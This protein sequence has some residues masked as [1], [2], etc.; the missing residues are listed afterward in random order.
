MTP[1][2]SSAQLDLVGDQQGVDGRLYQVF[3]LLFISA[4][5]QPGQVVRHV[6]ALLLAETFG[7]GQAVAQRLDELAFISDRLV[8]RVKAAAV[9]AC[10]DRQRG[11]KRVDTAGVV[12]DQAGDL[13]PVDA[14]GA[15]DGLHKRVTFERTIKIHGREAGDVE[16][17]HPHGADKGDTQRVCGRFKV[18]G[19]LALLENLLVPGDIYALARQLKKLFAALH[20]AL[21]GRDDYRHLG[22]VHDTSG[23]ETS[24]IHL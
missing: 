24:R 22:L 1:V 3:L 5:R 2:S 7:L 17:R 20:V 13:V 16:A 4:G 6:D 19:Q 9:F 21:G 14:V 10:V 18:I 23:A 11:F 8:A 15:G 12:N